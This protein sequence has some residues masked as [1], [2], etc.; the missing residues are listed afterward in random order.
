MLVGDLVVGKPSE[1]EGGGLKGG[2]GDDHIGGPPHGRHGS[3]F[4]EPECVNWQYNA[5]A[6]PRKLNIQQ[7][8]IASLPEIAWQLL[9]IPNINSFIYV[10]MADP[11]P[12]P[13]TKLV[14]VIVF[15]LVYHLKRAEVVSDKLYDRCT[16]EHLKLKPGRGR[17]RNRGGY[18]IN[19][20]RALAFYEARV[21]IF[22]DTG[23]VVGI[24]EYAEEAHHYWERLAPDER[25]MLK[26]ARPYLYT[27][28]ST[29]PTTLQ[30]TIGKGLARFRQRKVVLEF[31][32]ER[33][34][35]YPQLNLETLR[36]LLEGKPNRANLA[37]PDAKK[38]ASIG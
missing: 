19:E 35:L 7:K 8:E 21:R 9:Q 25:E 30:T 12:N 1:R 2:V 11:M 38:Q 28:A 16:S 37:L 14:D 29:L 34:E 33:Q 26:V 36:E 27:V 24:T 6:E 13:A 22:A 20:K 23:D 5:P 17:P 32:K 18:G 31:L 4:D 15:A 3:N 10:Y